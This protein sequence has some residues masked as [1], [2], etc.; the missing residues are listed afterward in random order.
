M[1]IAIAHDPTCPYCWIGWNQAQFLIEKYGIAIDWLSYELYPDHLELPNH[2]NPPKLDPTVLRTPS[3]FEFA[4]AASNVPKPRYFHDGDRIHNALEACEFAKEQGRQQR[5]ID[6][7]YKAI[8][9]EGLKANEIPVILNL[10]EGI[11]ENLDQLEFAL[12]HRCFE[13]RIVAFDEPAYH[14]GVH[15]VPTF[16]IGAKGYA[17]QP[18]SVVIRAIESQLK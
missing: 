14:S 10:A 6:R 18:L 9:I 13:D 12:K 7:L 17:E 8:W 3:R 4:I 5:F 15:H 16:W 2:P 1:Q 11:L